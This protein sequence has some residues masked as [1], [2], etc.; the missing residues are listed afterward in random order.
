[1]GVPEGWPL[2]GSARKT[3]QADEA[4]GVCPRPAAVPTSSCS[5]SARRISMAKASGSRPATRKAR[6]LRS[7]EVAELKRT[8]WM[9][10]GVVVDR[11]REVVQ[12]DDVPGHGLDRLGSL[13]D[14]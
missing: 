5:G 13:R 2:N 7:T 3:A 12:W 9:Q 8:D 6:E 4:D 10:K 1:L 11:D 14:G